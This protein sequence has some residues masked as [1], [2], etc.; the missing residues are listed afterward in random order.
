MKSRAPHLRIELRLEGPILFFASG[1]HDGICV[2]YE[3]GT[4]MWETAEC[5]QCGNSFERIIDED[6]K[7]LCYECW[8][9]SQSVRVSYAD[10]PPMAGGDHRQEGG[11]DEA[12]TRDENIRMELT[13]QYSSG[14]LGGNHGSP[15][16]P[17]R[18]VHIRQPCLPGCPKARQVHGQNPPTSHLLP[19]AP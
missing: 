9:E 3:K 2:S 15:A 8:E 18:P 5:A 16:A 6:W 17:E 19:G 13:V 7:T 11:S 4:G 12:L 1:G 10:C 14:H